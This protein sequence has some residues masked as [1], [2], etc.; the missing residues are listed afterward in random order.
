MGNRVSKVYT[1]TGD[2][3]NT[4]LADGSRVPKDSLRIEVL[5]D[6]DETNAHLGLVLSQ[7]LPEPVRADLTVVQHALFDLGG[8]LCLP[9]HVAIAETDVRWLEQRLDHYNAG[10][11]PLKEFVLP[12]GEPAAAHCHMA[13]TVCRRTERALVALSRDEQVR[14]PAIAFVNRLSDFLFVLAR[15][16]ARA[17]ARGEVLWEHGKRA[18]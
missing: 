8:E 10:L 15:T 14:A 7:A 6:L 11:P 17:G 3:G 2:T 13:R 18:G 9:G 12:G 1:R 4:G 16:L 5:G